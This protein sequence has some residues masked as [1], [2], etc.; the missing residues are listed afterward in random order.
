MAST[1]LSCATPCEPKC[2][3]P[4]ASSTNE[5]CVVTC[6]DSRVIIYPPP[7]VV[8]FPGPI[9]TTYPQQT[10]VGASEPSE[11]A[12]GEPPAP[13]ALPAEVT[14]GDKVAAPVL[15]RPE[16]RCA[17]KYSYSYSSQWTHPCNSYRSGKRWTC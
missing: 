7:V 16:P 5:P 15:A 6:G 2:P 11:V 9:L 12:L 13:A 14:A 17:P 4:L 10:V 3:Q 1:Q 8:T